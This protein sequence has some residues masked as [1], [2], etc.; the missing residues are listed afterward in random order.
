MSRM[1]EYVLES[2]DFDSQERDSQDAAA[3]AHQM[4]LDVL[5]GIGC[6]FNIPDTKM[7][8][9]C[10]LVNISFDEL[11]NHSINST[12][13]TTPCPSLVCYSANLVQ[14]KQPACVI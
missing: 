4:A 9:L 6:E 3:A 5:Y 14:E 2:Q 1:G 12:E 11:L 10:Q 7:R 13:S 8:E